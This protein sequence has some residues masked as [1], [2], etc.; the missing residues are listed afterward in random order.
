MMTLSPLINSLDL[1][2]ISLKVVRLRSSFLRVVRVG[3]PDLKL[4]SRTSSGCL[5]MIL[6]PLES[7]R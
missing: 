3:W 2:L 1:C 7:V 4:R 6:L 5:C